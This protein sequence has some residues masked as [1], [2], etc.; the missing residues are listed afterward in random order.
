MQGIA[1]GWIGGQDLLVAQRRGVELARL[2]ML[3][4][5]LQELCKTVRH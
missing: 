4:R 1:M 3:D 5:A 2:V